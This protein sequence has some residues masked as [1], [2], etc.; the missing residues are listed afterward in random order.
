MQAY[1]TEPP[2]N[3]S[4]TLHAYPVPVWPY[5]RRVAR[6]GKANPRFKGGRYTRLRHK[7]EIGVDR[8]TRERDRLYARI[9]AD[10]RLMVRAIQLGPELEHVTACQPEDAWGV[11]CGRDKALRPSKRTD[12]LVPRRAWAWAWAF[13][14]AV[15][16][17]RAAV[18]RIMA[19]MLRPITP[20]LSDAGERLKTQRID[21]NRDDW[22]A[23]TSRIAGLVLPVAA[24]EGREA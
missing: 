17:L 12:Y 5:A 9:Q 15:K 11:P 7:L 3:K 1:T 20:Y 23:V 14:R 4:R 19:M 22:R 16:D 13:I 24:P 6:C 10:A 18:A 8:Y 21:G 2:V